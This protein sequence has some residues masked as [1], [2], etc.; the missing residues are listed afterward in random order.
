MLTIGLTGGIASGKTTVANYFARLGVTIIDADVVAREVVEP[1]T[2]AYK[3]IVQHFGKTITNKNGNLNREKL[4]EIIFSN[5]Q[6]RLWLEQLLHPLIR[7]RM[8]EQVKISTSTYCI[9]VI[10]LLLEKGKAIKVDRILVVDVSESLQKERLAKR[11]HLNEAQ[12]NN[13]LK[14]QLTRSE[15]LIHAD[16]VIVNDG[17][18]YN[19][20]LQVKALHEKYLQLVSLA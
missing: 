1:G 11:D 16:D 17:D 10:P 9:L 3:E 15:R 12:A 20:E 2:S 8:Q 6:K 13:I 18:L 19:L 4:R 7:A 5:H 14:A